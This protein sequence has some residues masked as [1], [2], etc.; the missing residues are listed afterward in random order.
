VQGLLSP[1]ARKNGWQ[2]AAHAG[3]EA[4]YGVQPLL[5]RAVWA[6]AEVRKDLQASVGKH[7]GDAG[8]VLVVDETGLLKQGTKSV[9]VARQ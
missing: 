2:L 3:D 6:A 9:G 7:W 4:P 8:A 1:L 5:G